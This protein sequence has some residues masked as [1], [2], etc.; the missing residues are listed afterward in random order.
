M[1]PAIAVTVI[2][3]ILGAN[4]PVRDGHLRGLLV[5]TIAIGIQRQGVVVLAADRRWHRGRAQFGSH[6]KYAIHSTLP[7]AV[8]HGGPGYRT[9]PQAQHHQ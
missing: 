9:G 7:L 5:G 1:R 4:L 6:D 8:V 3:L 2:L